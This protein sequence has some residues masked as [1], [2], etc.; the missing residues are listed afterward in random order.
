M[1]EQMYS[2]TLVFLQVQ[3]MSVVDALLRRPFHT[4][5]HPKYGTIMRMM[6]HEEGFDVS[7]EEHM[8]SG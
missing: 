4:F 2:Q 6:D 5:T 1:P 3:N 8:M 7:F